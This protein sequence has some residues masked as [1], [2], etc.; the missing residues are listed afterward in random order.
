ML[1]VEVVQPG[2]SPHSAKFL[3]GNSYF[4]SSSSINL[5]LQVIYGTKIPHALK[6]YRLVAETSIFIL[7]SGSLAFVL[8]ANRILYLA[9]LWK[10]GSALLF[11]A[12]VI[13]Y[14]S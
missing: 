14:N 1:L 5:I 6:W 12:R 10:F 13:S 2:L 4:S 11:S 8:I 9:C 7:A 3:A